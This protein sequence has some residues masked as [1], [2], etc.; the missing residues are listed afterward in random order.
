[1]FLGKLVYPRKWL[2]RLHN[3]TKQVLDV[4]CGPYKIQRAIGMDQTRWTVVEVVHDVDVRP[5]PFQD[6]FFDRAVCR[7]SLEHVGNVVKT[8]E[9]LHRVLRPGGSLEI[10]APHFSSDNAFSDVTHR[11]FFGYRSMDDFC[12]NRGAKYQL[13]KARFQLDEVR[14]SFLQAAVFQNHSKSPQSFYSPKPNPF[15]LI[16]L[17]S[18]INLLPRLY[19]HFGAFVFRANEIYYRLHVLK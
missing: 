3:G 14:I 13:G 19:E 4:G 15:K 11:F 5:W 18:Q 16:G 7:H 6:A 8:M 2:A 17:E 9:E 10:L 1:M 12:A